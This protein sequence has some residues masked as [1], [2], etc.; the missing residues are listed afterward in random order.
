MVSGVSA[1]QDGV[2]WCPVCGIPHGVEATHCSVCRRRLVGSDEGDGDEAAVDASDAQTGALG[3]AIAARVAT[4]GSP[5]GG[6]AAP[7]RLPRLRQPLSDEEIDARAAA[8]VAQ[9]R[10]EEASG[11]VASLADDGL[12]PPGSG[13]P[14]I[15]DLDFLPPLRQ[16]DREWL[17]AGIVCC[18][19]LIV[20]AVVIARYFA[21]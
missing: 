18:V 1:A 21:A 11:A 17:L 3:R 2:V 7:W 20:G 12:L 16:R 8:I 5:R 15:A 4:Q 10:K 6:R 14:L 9:A 19:I 13:E